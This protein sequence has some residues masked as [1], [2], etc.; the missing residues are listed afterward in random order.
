MKSFFYEKNM[1][2][3]SKDPRV[4][5]ACKLLLSEELKSFVC[6]I[7]VCLIAVNMLSLI[8]DP[9]NKCINFCK[10]KFKDWT[11]PKKSQVRVPQPCVLKVGQKV[12]IDRWINQA[13]MYIDEFEEGRRAE[14]IMML[15][16]EQQRDRLESHALFDKPMSDKDYVEHLFVVIRSM[17]RKKE[18]SPTDNKDKF[19]KRKQRSDE[20]I[21]EYAED[22]KDSLYQ[23]WP[24]MPRDKLE[25]IL[26]EYFTAGLNNPETSA[27]IRIEKPKTLTK[28]VDIAEI[29]E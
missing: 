14:V 17:Y 27:R 18:G 1:W 12:D 4:Q 16:D 10:K 3:E 6:I 15:V 9:F 20:E 28:A 8:R 25:D 19:L 22:L 21:T 29:Y 11:K 13:R 23:A 2:C 7:V 24:G 5:N 26:I